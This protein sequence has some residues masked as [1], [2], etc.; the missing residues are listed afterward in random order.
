MV[1]FLISG[2]L[3]S[4]VA[5]Y[6][7]GATSAAWT[8]YPASPL[9]IVDDHSEE[10]IPVVHIDGIRNGALIGT[11]SGMVRLVAGDNPVSLSASGTFAIAD[12]S[13]LTNV[14]EIVIPPGM[15][16][17]ASAKGKKYYSITSAAGNQIVPQNRVY[18]PTEAS[19]QKAGYTK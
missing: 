2:F 17:V 18:F 5:G 19:A 6:S 10:D 15:H 12:T 4:L 16:F 3:L 8:L 13:I 7:I 14:I 1:R 9:R 11:V